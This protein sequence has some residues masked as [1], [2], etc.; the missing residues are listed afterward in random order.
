MDDVS[1]SVRN[2]DL[3]VAGLDRFDGSECDKVVTGAAPDFT[4]GLALAGAGLAEGAEAVPL[5]LPVGTQHWRA[6]GQPWRG[7]DAVPSQR[8][9]AR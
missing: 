7:D 4:S 9:P 3:D 8:V 6:Y 1:V 5:Y 2:F